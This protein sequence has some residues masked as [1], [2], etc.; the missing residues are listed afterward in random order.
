MQPPM[1]HHIKLIR[2]LVVSLMLV[3]MAGAAVAGPFEDAEAAFDRRDYATARRLWNSLADF[4]DARAQNNLGVMWRDGLGVQRD[5]DEAFRLFGFA[6]AQG[7]A[8]A[9]YN[10]GDLY[11]QPGAKQDLTAYYFWMRRAAS[12]GYAPAQKL[13]GK[14]PF[15]EPTQNPTSRVEVTLK[16]EGGTFVVPVL[17][18]GAIKLDF[19]VDSGAADVSVPADVFS[20]LRRTG[21]IND[22]DIIGDQRYV[23]AD[24]SKFQS[25]TFTIRSLKVGDIVIENVRGGVAPPQGSLLLGQS[26]LERFKSWSIDNLR[27]VLL[28]EPK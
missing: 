7:L 20:T 25:F 24:G 22:A 21:T 23:L 19:T 17:I 12:Q 11:S 10:L 5:Y 15:T 2:A 3:A 26:F 13:V 4:G 16:K 28:L 9:Q 6:A 27:H 18:N 8:E 1:R 14:P